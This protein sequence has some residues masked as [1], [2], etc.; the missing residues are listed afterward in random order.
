MD[1]KK[2]PTNTITRDVRVLAEPTGNIYESV[3]VLYKRANQIALQEKKELNKKLEDFKNE[4]DTLEEVFENREQ[5]EIS[6]YYERQPK[7]GLVAIEE[8]EEGDL[9]YRMAQHDSEE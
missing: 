6:K 8:F 2:V 4:R 3:V 9:Y 7:P 5:I 1:K